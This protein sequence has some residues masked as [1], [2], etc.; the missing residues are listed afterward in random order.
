MKP[1]ARSP[2]F[3][4]AVCTYGRAST[5]VETISR[6]ASQLHS[7]DEFVFVDNNPLPIPLPE[8]ITT[9]WNVVHEPEVGLSNARN[10]AL[11]EAK[12]DFVWFIDDDAVLR[13]TFA[14]AL[15]ALRDQL[16]HQERKH[17]P[18]FGGGL[19]IPY[20]C[21]HKAR[22]ELGPTEAGLLSCIRTSTDFHQPWGANMFVSRRTALAVGGFKNEYGYKGDSIARLGEE[23]DLFQRLSQ[24]AGNLSVLRPNIPIPGADV[25]HWIC[26]DRLRITWQVKRAFF[27]GQSNF[28]VYRTISLREVFF[29]L[30]RLILKPS[31]ET[32][33]RASFSFGK[34]WEKLRSK[35]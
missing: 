11:T 29:M 9:A 16:M 8:E 5:V 22:R 14:N 27:G 35:F 20:F 15:K 12:A 31:R 4:I 34:L 1:V 23:D 13:D 2:S 17:W 10:R 3:C 6:S 25:D 24:I 32:F 7:F 30:P 33:L 19:I 18:A 28:A 26:K 21:N